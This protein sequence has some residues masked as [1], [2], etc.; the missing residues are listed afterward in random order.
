MRKTLSFFAI[1]A[2]LTAAL[3]CLSGCESPKSTS[4]GLPDVGYVQFVSSTKNHKNVT[5]IFDNDVTIK[6]KV[7]STEDRTI[8][9]DSN[10]AVTT[11]RHSLQVLDSKGNTILTKD[12]FVSAQEI[13]IV[14]LP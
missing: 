14:Y 8:E 6:A 7:N 4:Y 13:R 5:A 11:G 12:I 10:Y 1:A 9:N 3:L 2:L